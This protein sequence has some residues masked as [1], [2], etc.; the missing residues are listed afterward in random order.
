MLRPIDIVPIPGEE[1][2]FLLRDNA[3]VAP[4][5]LAVSVPGY[6]ILAHLDGVHT[7]GQV[8]VA[9]LRQFGQMLPV[10][11]I[12]K[13]IE[14]LDSALMLANERSERAY[15]D[16]IARYRAA[17]TRDNR[18]RWPAADELRAELEQT[19]TGGASPDS[20]DLV[21]FIAPHLDY[22][23]GRPCYADAYAALR[24]APSA[25]RYIVLG[26]NHFGRGAGVVATG[27]DFI[28]PLGRVT[29]DRSLLNALN[30][31]LKF[32]LLA[33]EFDHDREHSIE[34]QV[35][36]LQ[37]EQPEWPFEIMPVLCPDPSRSRDPDSERDFAAELRAFADALC[38][39]LTRDDRRTVVIASADLSHVGQHF[40]EAE[41]TDDA[42]LADVGGHDRR[43]LELLAAH[44]ED[45]FVADVRETENHTRVCSVG[46]I[47]A[48]LR[49]LPDTTCEI[50]RYH[51]ATNF[52]A[53][54]HVT[55][56]AGV[57]L[58]Q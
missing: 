48:L 6:F 51:Q 20:P 40:G 38:D 50:R 46:C 4:H 32:D 22:E 49:A 29:T 2:R 52:P 3:G 41:P 34:L 5:Q 54:T 28:T 16:A 55:C 23:R 15:A 9:F 18:D 43:R 12:G 58:R 7:A 56:A 26:T 42:F 53:E 27:K 37:H 57:I 8:Q 47:Y 39:V 25:D 31:R 10:D 1:P 30:A 19:L 24:T 33:D 45:A 14:S 35:H 13:L 36:L 21:G 44:D 17:E 11:E